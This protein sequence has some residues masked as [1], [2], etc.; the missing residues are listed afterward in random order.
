MHCWSGKRE[1]AFQIP[2]RLPCSAAKG[3]MQS[4]L[5]L[6]GRKRARTL[7]G[8]ALQALP[9]PVSQKWSPMC[10]SNGRTVL[11]GIEVTI[12]GANHGLMGVLTA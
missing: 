8:K 11:T 4:N 6:A 1:A 3:A 12:H 9:R 7:F 5:R 10:C 2:V